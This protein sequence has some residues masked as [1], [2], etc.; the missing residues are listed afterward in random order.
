MG[1]CYYKRYWRAPSPLF[2]PYE[3]T[4]CEGRTRFSPELVHSGSLTRAVR[5]KGLLLIGCPVCDALL[6]WPDQTE[7][8]LHLRAVPGLSSLSGHSST[9]GPGQGLQSV[10]PGTEPLFSSSR[11][12]NNSR[13]PR[14][15]E[16]SGQ[17]HCCID[18]R[19][20]TQV[21]VCGL[22]IL[23]SRTGSRLSTWGYFPR[24]LGRNSS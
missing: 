2:S 19:F 15:K 12:V 20:C 8:R 17:P 1:F 13:S 22:G 7:T 16:E 3:D 23:F 9:G 24:L 11:E 18:S 5:N 21:E 14:D 6:Q 10:G 4:V